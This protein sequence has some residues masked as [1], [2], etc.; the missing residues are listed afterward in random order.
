MTLE[1]RIRK[2]LPHFDLEVDI[3]CPEAAMTV[4]IGPSGAGKTTLMRLIAGLDKAAAGHIRC[5]D[6]VWLDTGKGIFIPPQKRR[7]G[8]VFQDYP[9][10]PH[11][12][13]H[14]NAAFAAGA[15]DEAVQR[16]LA[17]FGIAHLQE[18][19]P[20]AVSGGERQRCAICQALAAKPRLL[21]LDEPFSALDVFTRRDLRDELHSLKEELEIPVIYITHDLNEALYLADELLPLVAGRVDRE[22]MQRSLAG[23]ETSGG[24]RQKAV[25]KTRLALAY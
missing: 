9:L 7:L 1:I 20:D 14:D 8:Y 13:L 17:R 15:G 12:N 21:L 19:K 5:S 4:V 11:L 10:F 16:L 6:E 23:V 2:P 3:D 24:E 22:W 18:R 25:R